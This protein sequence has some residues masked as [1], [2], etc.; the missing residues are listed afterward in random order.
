[1]LTE[2]HDNALPLSEDLA[3]A[4]SRST[5]PGVLQSFVLGHGVPEVSSLQQFVLLKRW[6]ASAHC[7]MD[8]PI[9]SASICVVAA[10]HQLLVS[11]GLNVLG[12]LPIIS[13]RQ[14]PDRQ[15]TNT[16]LKSAR[17]NFCFM[18]EFLWKASLITG[19]ASGIVK[20]NAIPQVELRTRM[21][22]CLNER[23]NLLTFCGSG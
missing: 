6:L 2:S 8:K 17:T 3:P 21:R 23:R 10:Q 5:H 19:T 12:T 4:K 11:C 18:W 9:Y 1:D 13:G 20:E 16:T 7:V 22:Y 15:M 14:H